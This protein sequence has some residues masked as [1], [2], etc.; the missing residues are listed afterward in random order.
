M[1]VRGSRTL[2]HILVVC[3]HFITRRCLFFE[4]SWLRT[5]QPLNVFFQ[6]HHSSTFLLAIRNAKLVFCN[7]FQIISVAGTEEAIL[8]LFAW[9]LQKF[10]II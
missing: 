6:F 9:H 1:C 7:I 5:D 4:T 2:T 8:V 3:F 10:M